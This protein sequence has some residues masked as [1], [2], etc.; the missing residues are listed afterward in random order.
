MYSAT[1]QKYEMVVAT[2]KQ[3]TNRVF[4]GDA[5]TNYASRVLSL[6][7]E[8]WTHILG[9]RNRSSTFFEKNHSINTW[10]MVAKIQ[11]PESDGT[12]CAY[13]FHSTLKANCIKDMG[14]LKQNQTKLMEHFINQS[15]YA[16]AVNNM[17]FG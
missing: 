12:K 8:V 15:L 6:F 10:P 17:A 7:N 4:D 13:L 14:T 1:A 9:D 16:R 11:I 2:I 3:H 5:N